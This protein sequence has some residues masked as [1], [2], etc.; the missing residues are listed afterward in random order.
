MRKMDLFQNECETHQ[1]EFSVLYFTVFNSCWSVPES[2]KMVGTLELN[3]SWKE[4]A[5][6][7]AL[8]HLPT[9]CPNSTVTDS[10]PS[11]VLRAP[12]MRDGGAVGFCSLDFLC[13]GRFLLTS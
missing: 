10:W 5:Y 1:I 11:F 7:T 4:H 2:R 6:G 8:K 13:A 9:R 3:S 12:N